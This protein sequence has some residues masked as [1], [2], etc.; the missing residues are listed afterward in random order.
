MSYTVLRADSTG[1]NKEI[2]LTAPVTQ[3]EQTKRHILAFNPDAT[4]EQLA[5]RDSWL[6]P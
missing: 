4:A 5:L 1:T 3:V 2:E 6:K